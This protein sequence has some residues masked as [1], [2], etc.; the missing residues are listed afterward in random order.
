MSPFALYTHKKL[1]HPELNGANGEA[2]KR[3]RPGRQKALTPGKED[4]FEKDSYDKFF[5]GEK[6]KKEGEGEINLEVISKEIFEDIYKGEHKD[7]L[8]E[9]YESLEKMPILNN[10]SLSLPPL[11][12]TSVIKN[13]FKTDDIFYEYLWEAKDK[14]NASYFKFLTKF[15]ILYRECFGKFKKEKDKDEMDDNKK[16]N[17]E[18]LPDICNDFYSDF[19]SKN[20]FFG[21]EE[22]EKENLIGLIQ[23]FCCWLF[24][25]EYTQSKLQLAENK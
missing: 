11:V 14:T 1:K 10:L 9:S 12:E 21:F 22:K 6:G 15:I 23:H 19:L 18:S 5:E 2:S 13:K 25:N 4:N 7:V 16:L 17:S 3:G 24:K 8:S 20:G